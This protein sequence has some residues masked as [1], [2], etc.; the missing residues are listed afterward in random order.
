MKASL[1]LPAGLVGGSTLVAGCGVLTGG[2][3]GLTEDPDKLLKE[4]VGNEIALIQAI[5]AAKYSGNAG[6]TKELQQLI[7]IHT[8]HA[9][10]LDPQA[11][12]GTP[13][14]AAA[15]ISAAAALSKVQAAQR[16]TTQKQKS[17][18]L[19]AGDEDLAF[20]LAIISASEAQCSAHLAG[21]PA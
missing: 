19:R 12:I 14:T 15:K 3:T 21:I 18:A 9:L 2:D 13:P 17:L 5:G 4:A 6:L 20:K 7:A 10:A 11:S 1:L 8:E 16:S